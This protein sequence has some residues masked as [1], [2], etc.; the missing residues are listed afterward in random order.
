MSKN[1]N[2]NAKNGEN[3]PNNNAKNGENKPNNNE[4]TPKTNKMVKVRFIAGYWGVYGVFQPKQ[5]AELPETV[6]NRFVKDGIAE[7]PKD[8]K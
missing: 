8:E 3:K 5:V 1:N 4:N 6:A 2:N 7:S